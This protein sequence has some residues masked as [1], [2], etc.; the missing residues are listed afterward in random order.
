MAAWYVEIIRNTPLLD[1]GTP[2]PTRYWLVDPEIRSA[3]GTLEAARG[4]RRSEAEVDPEPVPIA[5]VEWEEAETA[6]AA[7]SVSRSS[8]SPWASD[9]NAA[10]NCE[11]AR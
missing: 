10:S 8:A 2:M 7:S 3:I 5:D 1:D 6:A 4:V 9:T 11:G